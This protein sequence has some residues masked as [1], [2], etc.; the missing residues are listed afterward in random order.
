MEEVTGQLKV[1]EKRQR[2]TENSQQLHPSV[3]REEGKLKI[4]PQV[5]HANTETRNMKNKAI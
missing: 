3:P 5:N 1:M 2:K 4:K